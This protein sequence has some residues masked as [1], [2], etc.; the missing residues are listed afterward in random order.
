MAIL[1]FISPVAQDVAAESRN[2][3]FP[4]YP[5]VFAPLSRLPCRLRDDRPDNLETLCGVCQDKEHRPRARRP[6]PSHPERRLLAEA[7]GCSPVLV[8][9][10]TCK[11]GFGKW[12]SEVR[13]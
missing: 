6:C 9:C 7:Q 2:S 8:V 11:A 12:C 5:C 10:P 4:Q 13:S 1:E 3:D